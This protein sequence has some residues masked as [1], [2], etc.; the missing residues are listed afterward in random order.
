VSLVE[1]GPLH[2]FVGGQG[3]ER[4]HTVRK[5]PVA[6]CGLGVGEVDRS[7]GRHF[8]HGHRRVLACPGDGVRREHHVAPGIETGQTDIER[9]EHPLGGS[10]LDRDCGGGGAGRS[11]Q[12]SGEQEECGE[13]PPCGGHAQIQPVDVDAFAI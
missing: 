3:P 2:T 11:R 5:V 8:E 9:R 10:H 13:D 12:D 7:V 1:V 6:G 4:A